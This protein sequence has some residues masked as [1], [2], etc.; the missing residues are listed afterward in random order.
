MEPLNFMIPVKG[1]FVSGNMSKKR[2]RDYENRPLHPTNQQYEFGIA[3]SKSE[4]K[5]WLDATIWPY[6]S[7]CLRED[8]DALQ[9]L[10][11]WWR[12]MGAPGFLSMKIADGDRPKQRGNVDKNTA[13]CYVF[14]AKTYGY[15]D[16]AV[17]PSIVAG[18][19]ATQ[20][21]QIDLSRIKRGD[22]CTFAG[23][24]RFNEQSGDR[25]GFYLNAKSVWLLEEGEA[26]AGGG[27]PTNDFAGAT[28][29]GSVNPS[30]GPGAD[31]TIQ[32]T[33][34]GSSA[35]GTSPT[36][37]VDTRVRGTAPGAAPASTALPG[38]A[39]GTGFPPFDGV[40]RVPGT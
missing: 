13:G 8:A 12:N 27:D 28:L 31:F 20:L 1:R 24:Y 29:T 3:Y 35:P 2:D 19:S 40:L 26:I 37:H 9:R 11:E 7:N 38:N 34:P 6:A 33:A 30:A 5:P 18:P 10:T 39:L 36:V 32:G 21:A 22:Y 17:P 25:I 16:D 15:G 4:I 14:Y 23:N